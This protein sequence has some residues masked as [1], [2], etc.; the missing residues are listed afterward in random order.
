MSRARRAVPG[1]SLALPTPAATGKW[2]CAGDG[3]MASSSDP[4]RQPPLGCLAVETHSKRTPVEQKATLSRVW[5]SLSAC[6][7]LFPV[8]NNVFKQIVFPNFQNTY[9]T[10]RS[11]A[12]C[13]HGK[14]IEH[15]F[16]MTKMFEEG[17]DWSIPVPRNTAT[18]SFATSSDRVGCV[19]DRRPVV[20]AE[21]ANKES[22]L[23]NVLFLHTT[24]KSFYVNHSWSH[25]LFECS[26]GTRSLQTDIP[27][28]GIIMP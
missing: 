19:P 23:A 18:G 25:D 13:P 24:S 1:A 10:K 17:I 22:T 9:T 28:H 26:L 21:S 2:T 6:R 27:H 15:V 12:K 5:C 8:F 16:F 4:L 14:T 20:A 3:T 7:L 11:Y